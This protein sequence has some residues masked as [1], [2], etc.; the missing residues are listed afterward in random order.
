[1]EAQVV[2]EN[3]VLAVV[4]EI[5]QAGAGIDA[6]MLA[7]LGANVQVVFQVFL[8]DDLPATFTL[9]PQAFGANFLF[10]GRIQFDGLSFEPGHK[11]I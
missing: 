1:M 6:K 11:Q 4:E 2:A 8:P 7:A 5:R 3:F 9:Y 10:A